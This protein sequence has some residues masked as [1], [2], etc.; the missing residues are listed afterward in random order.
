ME[1]EFKEFLS[2]CQNCGLFSVTGTP[3]SYLPSSRPIHWFCNKTT[4]QELPYMM[5]HDLHCPPK[6]TESCDEKNCFLCGLSVQCPT[7]QIFHFSFS[8]SL[9]FQLNHLFFPDKFHESC[10]YLIECIGLHAETV[11]ISAPAF[12]VGLSVFAG[13]QRFSSVDVGYST[14]PVTLPELNQHIRAASV[15]GTRFRC[16]SVKSVCVC[17]EAFSLLTPFC[18]FYFCARALP[19]HLLLLS[20]AQDLTQ[21]AGWCS[22]SMLNCCSIFLKQILKQTAFSPSKCHWLA[23]TRTEYLWSA[24]YYCYSPFRDSA[25]ALFSPRVRKKDARAHRIKGWTNKWMWKKS[26]LLFLPFIDES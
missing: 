20:S 21:S 25:D 8:V 1:R 18:L 7:A 3:L 19:Y 14:T 11:C 12:S 9:F 2:F 4:V 6:M 24:V 23:N 10:Q 22:P 16:C 13:M 26:F 17:G 5:M 15:T